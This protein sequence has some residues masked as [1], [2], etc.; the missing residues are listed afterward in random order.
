MTSEAAN[1]RIVSY[2]GTEPTPLGKIGDVLGTFTRTEPGCFRREGGGKLHFTGGM[3]YVCDRLSQQVAWAEGGLQTIPTDGWLMRGAT[4]FSSYEDAQ[5]CVVQPAPSASSQQEVGCSEFCNHLLHHT[6][7]PEH[8]KE[9]FRSAQA[10]AL[11]R[12]ATLQESFKDLHATA[13]VHAGKAKV[14][15]DETAPIVKQKAREHAVVATQKAS[16]GAAACHEFVTHPD[17]VHFFRALK[18]SCV[19]G[20]RGCLAGC[21]QCIAGCLDKI[22]ADKETEVAKKA[23][24]DAEEEYVKLDPVQVE[25][26]TFTNE[27]TSLPTNELH[28]S[29]PPMPPTHTV[30]AS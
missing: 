22:A 30:A 16:E 3:W 19:D 13:S 28:D 18:T 2:V 5:I 1:T 17:T 15:Y 4:M 23:E 8:Q 25:H 26:G 14:Y 29:F 10:A 7:A 21:L 6:Q 24:A 20:M 27:H 12:S 9:T 11:K